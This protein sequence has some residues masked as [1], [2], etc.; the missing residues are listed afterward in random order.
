MARI[1]RRFRKDEYVDEIFIYRMWMRFLYTGNCP[2]F[3]QIYID[4]KQCCCT[5]YYFFLYTELLFVNVVQKT[6]KC[7]NFFSSFFFSFIFFFGGCI[8]FCL[9]YLQLL[10]ELARLE[11][12]GLF[13]SK[14][15]LRT[16]HPRTLATSNSRNKQLS[17][18]S[19]HSQLFSL[20]TLA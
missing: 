8:I 2:R 6:R 19:Q 4:S 7:Y 11:Q 12:E 18:H 20:L 3:I 10:P 16:R 13:F 14:M 5:C 9:I 1:W 17:Q 15:N